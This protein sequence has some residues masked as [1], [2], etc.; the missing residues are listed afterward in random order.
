MK[1]FISLFLTLFFLF[2]GASRGEFRKG[3]HGAVVDYQILGSQNNAQAG[4][5][6]A[7]VGD[8]NGDNCDDFLVG[9]PFDPQNGI[10]AGCVYLFFGRKNRFPSTLDSADVIFTGG[11]EYDYFGWSLAGLGDVNGDYIGDFV[12]G[13]F[14]A[15]PG[16]GNF[17]G[18]VFLFLGRERWAQ[19]MTNADA[20]AIFYGEEKGDR[21]GFSVAGGG[22]LNDDGLNDLVIAAISVSRDKVFFLGRAYIILGRLNGFKAENFLEEAD[23]VIPGLI[24]GGNFGFSADIVGDADG[25]QIDDLLISAPLSPGT[26]IERG[27]TYFLKGRRTWISP[28]DLKAADAVFKGDKDYIH[29]G[30]KVSG[31]GDV[32]GDGLADFAIGAPYPAPDSGKAGKIHLFFGRKTGW[33]GSVSLK[34]ANVHFLSADS[35]AEIGNTFSQAGDINGDRI[36][37]ILIGY[38]NMHQRGDRKSRIYMVSGHKGWWKPDYILSDKDIFYWT[39]GAGENTGWSLSAGDFNGNGRL[40]ILIGAP[41]SNRGGI[42]AGEIYLFLNR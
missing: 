29:S 32:N 34:D 24:P 25:D 31:T 23:V 22:D 16:N 18:A 27:E 39:E 40:E 8:V 30:T 2:S 36:A 6:L 37:D 26:G 14:N 38:P 1:N 28:L 41:K 42:S 33:R 20:D 21:A 10:D 3:P 12:I 7:G 11:D 4:F 15:E 9:A 35:A 19:V 17:I 5:S 13:G